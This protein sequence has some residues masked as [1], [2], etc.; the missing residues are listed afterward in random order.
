MSQESVTAVREF[1]DAAIRRDYEVALAAIHPEV[2]WHSPP[3]VPNPEVARGR[4][5]YVAMWRD[6][7]D[8]WDDYRWTPDEFLVGPGDTVI[9]SGVES[10]RGRGSGIDV[11]SRRVTGVF[12]VRDRKIVRFKAYLDRHEALEAARVRD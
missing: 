12:E 10:A 11:L 9:V 4:D 2:E 6:W 8:A 3:D 7:V 1:L 5:E